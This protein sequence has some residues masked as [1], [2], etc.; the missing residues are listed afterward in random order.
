MNSDVDPT[1]KKSV[2]QLFGKNTLASNHSQRIGLNVS[3]RFDY[4]DA[5]SKSWVKLSQ[6]GFGLFRLSQGE[7]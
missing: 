4:L 3:G 6:A 2:F 1:L 5:Y 7:L